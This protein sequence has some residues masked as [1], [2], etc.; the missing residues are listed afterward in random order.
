[1]AIKYIGVS[2]QLWKTAKYIC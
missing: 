2:P 1:M